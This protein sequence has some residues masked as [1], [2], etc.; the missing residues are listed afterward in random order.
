MHFQQLRGGVANRVANRQEQCNI[1]NE[2]SATPRQIA[3]L[4]NPNSLNQATRVWKFCDTRTD[5]H[6]WIVLL[7]LIKN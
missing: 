7:Y 2:G 3:P 4:R 5:G 6:V 1:S